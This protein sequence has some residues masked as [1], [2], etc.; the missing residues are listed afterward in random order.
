M[1]HVGPSGEAEI[2]LNSFTKINSNNFTYDKLKSILKVSGEVEIF[3]QQ[4]KLYIRGENFTYYK[5]D[6]KIV[7]NNKSIIIYEDKYKIKTKHINNEYKTTCKLIPSNMLNAFKKS[8]KHKR[9]QYFEKKS[10]LYWFFRNVSL[11]FSIT[12]WSLK[13]KPR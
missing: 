7:G 2:I 5:L 9:V 6:E 1:W 10:K 8:K 13:K 3:D 4:N 12:N 11:M